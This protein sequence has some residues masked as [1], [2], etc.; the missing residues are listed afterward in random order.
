VI[1]D[2]KKVEGTCYYVLKIVSLVR[3][4]IRLMCYFEKKFKEVK[5]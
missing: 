4:K 3:G 1:G 5:V 2:A